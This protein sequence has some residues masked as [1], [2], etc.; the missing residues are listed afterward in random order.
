[1]SV[2][3][4]TKNGGDKLATCLESIDSQVG[5]FEKQVIVIDSGST[6]NTLDVARKF[7]ATLKEIPADQF[8]HGGAR[9]LGAS[10]ASGEFIVFCN[11]DVVGA[12]QFWFQNLIHPFVDELVAATYSR[13]IAPNGTHGHERIF[14]EETYPGE[15]KVITKEMLEDRGAGEVVLFSTVSACIR[16]DA[17]E[18]FK[19]SDQVIISEDQEI[20]TRILAANRYIVY[21]AD[22]AVYHSNEYTLQTAFRRY[23]DSGWSMTHTPNLRVNNK[24][25]TARYIQNRLATIVKSDLTVG[26]KISAG[27]FL[28]AKS[29]GFAMGLLVPYMPKLAIPYLSHTVRIT[30]N[31]SLKVRQN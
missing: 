5:A 7:N 9:N 3:I 23:F 18:R 21:A 26:E 16:R 22:S 11:Q 20:A 12:D 4:P 10:L 31:N 6:D 2:V 24:S 1:M 13:Q 14:I 17:W 19:F 8:T 29:S 27:A 25:K 30:R 15:S 28:F